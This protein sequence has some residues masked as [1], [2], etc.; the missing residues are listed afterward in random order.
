[1]LDG[2]LGRVAADSAFAAGAVGA[3]GAVLA[4]TVRRLLAP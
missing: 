3:E 2:F 4:D 1:V